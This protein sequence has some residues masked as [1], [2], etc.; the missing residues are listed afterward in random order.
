MYIRKDYE[1]IEGL[2][3][4]ANLLTKNFSIDQYNFKNDLVHRGVILSDER[5]EILIDTFRD[6]LFTISQNTQLDTQ[7]VLFYLI[8]KK[9]K[10]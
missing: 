10:H 5:L 8:H 4:A 1:N 9:Q 6:N 3:K 2:Q 7:K